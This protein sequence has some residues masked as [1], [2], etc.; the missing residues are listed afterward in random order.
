MILNKKL[1]TAISTGAILIQTLTP[2]ALADTTVLNTGNGSAST[3]SIDLTQTHSSTVDQTNSAH[4]SNNVHSNNNTGD[5]TASDNTG[6]MVT[7]DT[8]NASSDT[9]IRNLANKNIA[10]GGCGTCGNDQTRAENSGNGSFSSNDIDVNKSTSA[11]V[12]Q[13]NSADF[14]N[15]VH[16]DNNTG[17]NDANRN[18]GDGARILTG[19]AA[20]SVDISNTANANIAHLGGNGNGLGSSLEILNKGNGSASDNSIDVTKSNSVSVDQSNDAY[21]SNEVK[22]NNNTGDNFANDNTGGRVTIDTGNAFSDTSVSN[23]ANLNV[24][25]VDCLCDGDVLV[26]NA[27]NGSFSDNEISADLSHETDV[28]QTNDASFDNYLRNNNDTGFNDMS[29]NTGSVNGD[30]FTI[31]GHSSS[32]VDVQNESNLNWFNGSSLPQV[33]LTWDLG[34]ALHMFG[35]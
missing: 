34:G 31:T 1:A 17:F 28:F 12:S 35:M 20:D 26:K 9:S 16:S 21:F 5:N 13:S 14:Y 22:S 23:K 19:H 7:I 11:D 24:A 32:M 30:P 25:R 18:T 29:R 3:N 33:Q 6:G 2:M 10:T 4:I 8:G 15:T 27:S